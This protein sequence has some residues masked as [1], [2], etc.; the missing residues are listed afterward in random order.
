MTFSFDKVYKAVTDMVLAK[1]L[2]QDD[3]VEPTLIV[4]Q[5]NG[6]EVKLVRGPSIAPLFNQSMGTRGKD[7]LGAMID[8]IMT[9]LPDDMCVVMISEAYRRSIKLE[10]GMSVEEARNMAPA[11]LVNDPLADEILMVQMYRP[12]M[13]RM[14][15]LPILPGRVLKYAD[16]EDKAVTSEGRLAPASCNPEKATK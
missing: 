2:P 13:Q 9:H 16:M 10:E 1:G 15:S 12:G 4:A 14:G 7:M 8:S 11:S 3:I 5:I 6:D